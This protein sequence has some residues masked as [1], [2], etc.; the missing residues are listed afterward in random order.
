[1]PQDK[2]AFFSDHLS[3]KQEI[4]QA[5]V[6]A[7]SRYLG[8]HSVKYRSPDTGN[9]PEGFD[10][11][12]LVQRVLLDLELLTKDGKCL[13]HSEEFFC[14]LGIFVHEDAIRPGDIV[15]FSRNGYRPDHLGFYTGD[16]KMIH[17]PGKEGRKVEIVPIKEFV[18]KRPLEYDPKSGYSQIYFR[19]PIGYKRTFSGKGMW[20]R[21]SL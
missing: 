11:S 21:K 18:S 2:I 3:G 7:A 9:T 19:N 13:R 20:S 6:A 1:M 5:I 4:G 8:S 10:C 17:S 15:F 12:G 14:H 16:G